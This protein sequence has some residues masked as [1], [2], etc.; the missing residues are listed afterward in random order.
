MQGGANKTDFYYFGSQESFKSDSDSYLPK[1]VVKASYKEG[2]DQK[3]AQLVLTF[4]DNKSIN[5]NIVSGSGWNHFNDV[6]LSEQCSIKTKELGG[7]DLGC[8]L[9][10][11]DGS[12]FYY[13]FSV[14]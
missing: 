11:T 3:V 14:F 5:W 9:K 10:N 6:N 8:T 2:Q 4:E 12:S 7:D 13:S 1:K